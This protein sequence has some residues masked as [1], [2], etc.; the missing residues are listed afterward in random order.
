MDILTIN[1]TIGQHPNSYYVASSTPPD[2]Y[3]AAEGEIHADVC[4][5]GGG[6]SGLSAA[7]HLARQGLQVVLLEANRLG[8]GASGRNGGQVGAGQRVEQGELEI[9]VGMERAKALWD[10]SLES[11]QLVKQLADESSIDCHYVDG[12]L[13]ANHRQRYT[14]ETQEHVEHLQQVYQYDQIRFLG[15]QAIAEEV[16]SEDY[17]SGYLDMG[18]GHIHPLRYVFALVELAQAAGVKIYE[19]SRMTHYTKGAKVQV[20]TANA[21]VKANQLIL[22]LNG[23]HNNIER[24][25][26]AKV[27][28]INNFIC[29]TEPLD[30]ALAQSLIRNNY[31]VA[32]SRFVINYFRL[33]AD[34]RLLFGGGESYGYKFPANLKAKVCQPMLNIYPQLKD[35]PID[36]AWGGTLGITRS[37]LPYFDRLEQNV[38]S[39]AGFSGHGVA[40]ATQAGKMAAQVINGQTTQFDLLAHIPAASFPGG[41]L[42]RQPLL[43]AAMLWYAMRDKL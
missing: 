35:T 16:G 23:Y 1:D 40:M 42:L 9:M 21:T 20:H 19:Q 6:F 3:P 38:L 8:S 24:N 2:P 10:M 31:A 43:V 11:V 15:Q 39:I 26:T 28:P 37:R 5:V 14:E 12:V 30:K 36:Y 41:A 27:M 13:H 22:A 7:L 17:H 18:S 32:D 4:V 29:A 33:S 34:N 25:L